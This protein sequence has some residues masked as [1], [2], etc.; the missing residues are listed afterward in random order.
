MTGET[1]AVGIDPL[2]HEGPVLHHRL[3]PGGESAGL[4]VDRVAEGR[5]AGHAVAH[6]AAQAPH[7]GPCIPAGNVAAAQAETGRRP[8]AHLL[9]CK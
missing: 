7:A 5:V 6:Q 4:G 2:L 9:T 1:A 3:D 8:G